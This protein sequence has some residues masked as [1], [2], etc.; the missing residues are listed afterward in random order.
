[1][2]MWNRRTPR[3]QWRKAIAVLAAASMLL[4][5]A[6]YG[7]PSAGAAARVVTPLYTAADFWGDTAS[8]PP[9]RNVLQVKIL[10]RTNGHYPDNQVY[11][12]FGG[13][14]HSI[15]EQPLIDMPAN[16][17][18]RMNF[19]L[20]APNSQYA[21]FIEFTV[22]PGVFNGNTTRVDWFGIKLALRLHAADGY[23]VQVGEDLATFNEDRAVT[24]QKFIDAVPAEFDHLAQDFAPFRI[25]APGKMGDTGFLPGGQYA[26]YMTG[27]ASQNGVSASTFDV[28]ACAGPLAQ[29][30]QLCAGLNRHVGNTAGQTNPSSFYT[31]APANYYAKFW[32][33]HAINGLAYGFPYD[34]YGNQSSFVTHGNP[35]YLLVAVGW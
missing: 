31:A 17:A 28:L 12:S 22:N 35:Q 14:T 10:N 4:A 18:G 34:D 21:D 16:S 9:A 6:A 3:R 29:N 25:S 23:D 27:Y 32:H 20:G 30:P 1:V 5:A 2:K 11:W 7:A 8:I 33:D 13:Q 15:A 24:F 19:F 26:N